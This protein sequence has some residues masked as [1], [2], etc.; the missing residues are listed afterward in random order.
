MRSLTSLLLLML[1]IMS[2][3]A[4]SGP[5]GRDSKRDTVQAVVMYGEEVLFDAVAGL[6]DNQVK[7]LR[8]SVLKFHGQS[9][10]S[11]YLELYISL[12]SYSEEQLVA[13]I[14]S[15]F[16]T[17]EV[18]YALINQINIFL[19]NRPEEMPKVL[20]KEL[21]IGSVE[22]PIPAKELYPL[23][24][25][26]NPNPYPWDLG[27]EDT[28]LS[29]LLTDHAQMGEF[30]LPVVNTLT[31]KFGWRDGRMHNGIDI[32]LEVW[33]PV[34]A[35]FPGVVR[36]AR[37]Y[38]GYG[39]VVVVR[40]YNGL[41]TLYAHLHRY[42]VKEGDK[43]EAGQVLGLGGSSGNSTG[44]HLHFEVRFKGKPINPLSFISFDE[45]AL[46]NDTLVLKRTKHGYISY[47]KGIIIYTVKKG[48]NLYEIA[49]LYGTTTYKLAEINGIR[50]NG[51]LY[52]GQRLRVI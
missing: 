11:D 33:D 25:N 8:D 18:P 15:L 45:Q 22:I 20:P 51:Y 3:A 34:I 16:E 47:P 30:Q 37:N 24:D 39:R 28:V 12:T 42:K 35:A 31:S 49:R 26:T 21:F 14:D 40:H 44:S 9:K 52:V 32:D 5:S 43:V 48:D 46:V 38:G 41:E 19:A 1:G 23:W 13:Y 29:I 10:F 17:E 4:A 27:K 50:R 7:D 6:T 2:V 36:M